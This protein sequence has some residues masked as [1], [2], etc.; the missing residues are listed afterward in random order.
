MSNLTQFITVVAPPSISLTGTNVSCFGFSDG[1]VISNVSGSS[2]VINYSWN[3]GSTDANLNNL[4]AGTYDLTITDGN[5]CTATS[6]ITIPEPLAISITLV[7]NNVNCGQSTGSILSNVSNG[8]PPYIYLWSNG[9]RT[10]AADS[11]SPGQYKLEVV[12]ANGCQGTELEDIVAL[13]GPQI[14]LSS[15]QNVSCNGLSNGSIN[16]QVTGGLAPVNVLWSNGETST[17][18][19]NL[20]AGVYDVDVTDAS[21]CVANASFT[22]NEPTVIVVVDSVIQPSCGNSDGE[23]FL[24]ASGGNPGGYTYQWSSNAGGGFASSVS[25]VSAG[26]YTVTVSDVNFCFTTEILSLSNPGNTIGIVL[27]SVLSS[28][29]T[30]TPAGSLYMTTAGNAQPLSHYWSNGGTTED[31]TNA[32]PGSYSLMVTDTNQCVNSEE[33]AIPSELAGYRPEICLVT[34]DDTI[35]RNLVIW[36]KEYGRGIAKYRIY[37]Q[38][39][40]QNFYLRVAEVPFDSLSI[41]KDSIANVDIRSWR[42]KIS[43]VDS[44]G[45]ETPKSDFQKTIHLVTRPDTANNKVEL[46]WD[47]YDG[48]PFSKYYILRED[49]AGYTVIDSVLSNV[50]SYTDLN[51]PSIGVGY[52]IDAIVSQPCNPT[53]RIAG[54]NDNIYATIVK[55]RSNVKNNRVA[56]LV[57]H[58][59]MNDWKV[60]PVPAQQEIFVE[61]SD[62]KKGAI[63]ELSNLMGQLIDT[64]N[65]NVGDKRIRMDVSKLKPGIYFVRLKTE[66]GVSVQRAV[67]ER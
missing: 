62:N 47:Y 13:N 36:N 11:L 23:V 32:I 65:M 15:I 5:L 17:T 7:P 43:A 52:R 30:A 18:N 57:K 25:N 41:F 50:L 53:L 49:I 35:E 1:A 6:S 33:L 4:T 44:C 27:D 8:T 55:T 45:F 38:T 42:Y 48:L 61:L 9:D 51:P 56:G 20:L 21:G 10:L 29:C 16:I 46:F 24:T 26:I 58:K 19:S 28:N 64:D 22:V 60:F 39:S 66:D 31:L 3:T 59:Q 12:D 37:R 63:V 34:V 67:I 2:G 14:S 40:L 54:G